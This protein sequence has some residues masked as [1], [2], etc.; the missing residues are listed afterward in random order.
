MDM[1]VKQKPSATPLREQVLATLRADIMEGRLAPGQRVTERELTERLGVSRTVLRES[2]RQLAAE[3]LVSLVP[4]KGTVIRD[5][6]VTEARELYRIREMLEGL[7]ARLFAESAA[8]AAKETLHAALEAVCRAYAA[9]EPRAILEA[10]NRYYAVIHD[11]M[12]SAILKEMLSIVLDRVW[13]WRALGLS[14]PNRSAGRSEES[15]ANLIALTEAIR[16]GDGDRAE[17]AARHE[18]R[19]AAAE[20]ILLLE[21]R[22][23]AG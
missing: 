13:R 3:G 14:H 22:G 23:S 21:G 8:P 17:E 11:G 7:S 20:V 6:T 15:V 12:E 10:K 9:G 2:L 19:R 5:L 4:N 16:M 1:A 18:S